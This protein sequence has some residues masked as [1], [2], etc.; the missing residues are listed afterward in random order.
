MEYEHENRYSLVSEVFE[1]IA[2]NGICTLN[3]ISDNLIISK[4]TLINTI[5]TLVNFGLLEY[6]DEYNTHIR[7]SKAARVI[8]D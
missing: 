6:V 4:N 2:T 1:Y 8:L 7:L 3:E 5:D